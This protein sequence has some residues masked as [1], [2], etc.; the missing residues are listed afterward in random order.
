LS[1]RDFLE[2]AGGIFLILLAMLFLAYLGTDPTDIAT[3]AIFFGAGI[4][5]V[6]RGYLHIKARPATQDLGK[7]EQKGSRSK[8]K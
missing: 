1:A 7:P 5:I 2:V 6:R 8:K 3:D 4:L